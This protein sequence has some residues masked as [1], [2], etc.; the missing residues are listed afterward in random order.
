MPRARSGSIERIVP[1]TRRQR[2]VQLTLD[3][4]QRR[5]LTLIPSSIALAGAEVELMPIER[6]ERRLA[7]LSPVR[8]TSTISSS[9]VRRPSAC[10]R[11][12]PSPQP[13]RP[14]PDPM[15]VLRTG[16][17]GP[18]ARDHPA[19][20]RHLNPSWRS[21]CRPDDVRRPHP[22]QLEVGE[23]VR[24]HIGDRV[25][26]TLIPRASASPKRP[27]TAAAIS[28]APGSRGAEAYATSRTRSSPGRHAATSGRRPTRRSPPATHPAPAWQR[29]HDRPTRSSAGSRPRPGLAD[30]KRSVRPPAR[31]R[32]RSRVSARTLASLAFDGRRCSPLSPRAFASTA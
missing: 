22:T 4:D 29:A 12:T 19:H 17:P 14:H 28:Y 20:R 2:Q 16:R 13:I 8:T 18:A 1:C 32:S 30:P 25:F 6:R 26:E 21:R 9:I 3:R 10:S 24:R 7:A 15:R 23:E 11:S 5:G 31:S 27:A